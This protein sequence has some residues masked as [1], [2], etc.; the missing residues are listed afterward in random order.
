MENKVKI[1]LLDTGVLGELCHPEVKMAL[2]KTRLF[3]DR[4]NRKEI[5]VFLPEVTDYFIKIF[6]RDLL[7]ELF[8]QFPNI[9]N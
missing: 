4:I 7:C 3:V 8:S 2:P 5:R 9:F 1:F 6:C